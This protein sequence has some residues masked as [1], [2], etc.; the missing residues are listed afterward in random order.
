[1]VPASSLPF[2][3]VAVVCRPVH[4][5]MYLSRLLCTCY[6]SWCRIRSWTYTSHVRFH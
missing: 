1:M 4:M 5:D 2:A 6:S 3:N